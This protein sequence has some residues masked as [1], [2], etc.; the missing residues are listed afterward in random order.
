MT[1]A[2]LRWWAAGAVVPAATLTMAWALARPDLPVAAA[3]VR[4]VADAA[5]VTAL[6]LC[7]LPLL[8]SARYRTELG[9][10]ARGPLIIAAAI[11][12]IGELA[13]LI[14]A[15]AQAA[16]TSVLTLSLASLAQF[17][18]TTPGRATVFS[19]AA[20]AA[21][22]VLGTAGG[23][24]PVRRQA[25]IAAA[26]AGLAARSVSGH[27][28]ESLLGGL[29][30]AVHALAAGLWCGILAALLLAVD[31]RG[32]WSRLLPAFSRVALWSVIALLLGGVTAALLTVQPQQLVTTGYGRLLTAKITVLIILL[33]LA[34]RHRQG[35]VTAA[36][37]HRISSEASRI[38][39]AAEVALMA[40]ALT[41]A[42]ALSVTG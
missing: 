6:G 12:L 11:W 41:I 5:T 3:A 8:E 25:L 19:I 4:A 15:A 16:G 28:S 21:A 34:A 32:Q 7:V 2:R 23:S 42:A 9:R 22:A 39:S 27:L 37:S 31:S 29:A 26:A 1:V 10:R 20:A 17:T 33:S 35:W 13:S 30:V 24:S 36:R 14:I 40:V 38:R 18:L